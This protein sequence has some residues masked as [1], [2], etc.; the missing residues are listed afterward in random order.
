MPVNRHI[1]NSAIHPTLNVCDHLEVIKKC[2]EMLLLLYVRNITNDE[3]NKN[4]IEL[5]IYI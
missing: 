1:E 5:K 4:H 3:Y 2:F